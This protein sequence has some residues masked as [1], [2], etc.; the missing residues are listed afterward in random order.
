MFGGELDFR[1]TVVV[2]PKKKKKKPWEFTWNKLK[3]EGEV[4]LHEKTWQNCFMIICNLD[5][6][7]ALCHL[8]TKGSKEKD[9]AAR[10]VECLLLFTRNIQG[11]WKKFIVKNQKISIFRAYPTRHHNYKSTTHL[12]SP[13]ICWMLSRTGVRGSGC[14]QQHLTSESI[15]R[16]RDHSVPWHQ[17]RPFLRVHS[18][19]RMCMK[20]LCCCQ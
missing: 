15:Y 4:G 17:K 8:T 18:R 10:I 3:G 11:T 20:M 14:N 2:K 7:L 6:Y 16:V 19:W 5:Q 13:F 9:A 1:C 12:S